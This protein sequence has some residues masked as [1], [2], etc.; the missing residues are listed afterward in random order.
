MEREPGVYCE[1]AQQDDV[2]VAYLRGDLPEPERDAFEQ[3]FFECADCFER[4]QVLRGLQAE[5]RR[6]EAAPAAAT[7]PAPRRGR[8]PATQWL[9]WAAAA[10]FVAVAATFVLRNAA[11]PGPLPATPA[12]VSSPLPPVS[13]EP[14]ASGVTA[15]VDPKLLARVEPPP[16]A[17]L[18]TRGMEPAPG[19]FAAAMERYVRG[20]YAGA[21]SGLRAAIGADP[22]SIEA[23]FYLGVSELLAGR[24]AEAIR[25]LERVTRGEDPA[26][27]EAARY[28]LAKA[29][30]ARG[31]AAAARRELQRVAQGDGDHKEQARELLRALG[32]EP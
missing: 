18:I 14:I 17:P 10:A 32:H 8:R 24:P 22:S 31:D 28:Y 6:P 30:L 15:E 25:E 5:L 13:D 3:H 11:P 26:F 16:Y 12:P 27:A 19:A 20:D 21:A 9:A 4:L 23:R 7:I 29:H 1:R 2:A